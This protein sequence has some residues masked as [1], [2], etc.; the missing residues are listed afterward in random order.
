LRRWTEQD[1]LLQKILVRFNSVRRMDLW[2][3]FENRK[4]ISGDFA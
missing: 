4:K 3:T 2:K 1:R